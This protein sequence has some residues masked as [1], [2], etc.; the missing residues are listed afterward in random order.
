[1]Q[2]RDQLTAETLEATGNLVDSISATLF[3][4]ISPF[5]RVSKILVVLIHHAPQ[6]MMNFA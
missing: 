3:P 5:L 1:M 4:P 2:M 6:R